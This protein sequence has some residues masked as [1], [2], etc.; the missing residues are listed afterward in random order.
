MELEK[1]EEAK[2][3]LCDIINKLRH[4]DIDVSGE[5]GMLNHCENEIQLER[6]NVQIRI[7]QLEIIKACKRKMQTFSDYLNEKY[8]QGDKKGKF[9]VADWSTCATKVK[10]RLKK[11]QFGVEECDT[12][13][14][15]IRRLATNPVKKELKKW[16]SQESDIWKQI[17]E[18]LGEE[19]AGKLF[20]EL[21]K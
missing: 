11:E 2:G 12:L 3:L 4:N 18:Y 10:Q 13:E 9:K 6:V 19:R 7:I 5:E 21:K 16:D 20:E 14:E 1:W 8:E 15:V 17:K